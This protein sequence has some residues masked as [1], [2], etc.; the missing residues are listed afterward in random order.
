MIVII[1]YTAQLKQAANCSSEE[2]SLEQGA[3]A[4]DAI[5]QVA[6]QHGGALKKMLITNES[7]VSS[8]LLFFVDDSQ[9]VDIES[10]LLSEGNHITIMSPISGG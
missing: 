3:T 1:E 9:V 7:D 2:I 8:S 5:L 6:Q 4:R 10:H